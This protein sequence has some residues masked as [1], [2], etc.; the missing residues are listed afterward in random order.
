M[1]RIIR[2]NIT[3]IPTTPSLPPFYP[4]STKPLNLSSVP[5]IKSKLSHFYCSF[6]TPTDAR[7]G[8]ALGS[9]DRWI[10]RYRYIYSRS[11]VFPLYRAISSLLVSSSLV[12]LVES[13][14]WL[15][16]LYSYTLLS[17]SATPLP[18]CSAALLC[19][20]VVF[21]FRRCRTLVHISTRPVLASLS[22]NE[23]SAAVA[24]S[25]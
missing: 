12:R 4:Q 21:Y 23:E 17:S 19:S 24:L 2:Y 6:S 11:I 25:M 16:Q 15:A 10:G 20:A 9:V 8:I 1:H 3:P 14:G 13:R 5:I 7:A 22:G 18:S